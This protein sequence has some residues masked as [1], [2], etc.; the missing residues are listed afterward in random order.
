MNVRFISDFNRAGTV[1]IQDNN[2]GW[3]KFSDPVKILTA[4][5][6]E[7]VIP[8][9]EEL[10][11]LTGSGFS[12]AGFMCYEAARGI[13]R[14]YR[15]HDL[16]HMPCAWFGFYEEYERLGFLPA[17]EETFSANGWKASV[18]EEEFH[19]A[20]EKIRRH[21][22]SGDTYQ[23]NYTIR[24]RTSFSGDPYAFFRSL[25]DSQ[26]AGNCAFLSIGDHILCSVSPE[27]FFDLAG[28][29]ITCR[30]MKG[31]V[32]RGL[33]AGQD[34]ENAEWLRTSSKNRA[35]NVMIV[36]MVRND[37]GRTAVPGSIRPVSLFDIERYPTVY[38][39]T[40]TVKAEVDSG[41]TGIM[42]SLFPS[43]SITGAPKVRTMEIIHELEPEPRG[44][45]T[46]TIGYVADGRARFNVSIRTVCL[47]TRTGRAEY[48]VGGG[49]VWD[50]DASSEYAECLTKADVLKKKRPR[51]R[52]L[53]T[54][55]WE[56]G[57]GFF[58]LERHLQRIAGS[59][60]YFG[61]NLPVENIERSLEE[62]A[63]TFSGRTFTA[64]LL[65]DL[66]GAFEI[67]RK[68]AP[69]VR[70]RKLNAGICPVPV[71][72]G[73]PFLYHKT[74]NRGVY[75]RA[76]Q[77]MPDCDD[78]ILQ[79]DRGELTETTIA[80]LVV[81]LGGELVTPPATCGLLAGTFRGMLLDSGRITEKIL[82]KE[83]LRRATGVYLVNSVRKWVSVG[84][85]TDPADAAIQ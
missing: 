47:D 11:R 19:R 64:R 24:L 66:G 58:L 29:H 1:L 77:T 84:T 33:T 23:V 2:G 40:S 69:P 9:L 56:R 55:L 13:D 61:F 49:I 72:P 79:N 68:K 59:A 39:M 35:E 51:F 75:E 65:V 38:Q 21:I 52:L 8:L 63:E 27:L 25:A 34:R 48:G 31:T 42:K 81:E 32:A 74:T 83:D 14:V 37:L 60:E 18:T 3:L 78:V 62:A 16:E 36:D 20:A 12:A 26:Q 43:A 45:Y 46:G 85:V 15:V 82:R 22:S 73:D 10:D 30:P 7:D 57:K 41:L 5:C 76:A 80:N 50:S 71:D 70:R 67:E 54:I 6:P 17:T 53:E 4:H 44:I 28:R